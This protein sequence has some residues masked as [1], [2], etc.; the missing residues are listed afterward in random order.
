MEIISF[1]SNLDTRYRF[2]T[3]RASFSC[4]TSTNFTSTYLSNAHLSRS[5]ISESYISQ[6]YL[7][8]IYVPTI[9]YFT[10]MHISRLCIFIQIH[11]PIDIR[12]SPSS[13]YVLLHLPRDTEHLYMHSV[14]KPSSA[15]IGTRGLGIPK[16]ITAT[17]PSD[18]LGSIKLKNYPSTGNIRWV[19]SQKD[20]CKFI[21]MPGYSYVASGTNTDIA[22]CYCVRAW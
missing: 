15:I 7:S 21:Q 19:R 14:L 10:I 1:I 13:K 6:L 8:H 18:V 16:A 2:P 11:L 22:T 17:S 4:P 20:V 12:C 5:C 3:Y 9:S